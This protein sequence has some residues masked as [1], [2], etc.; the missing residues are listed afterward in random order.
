ML[1][2]STKCW[3]PQ[4]ISFLVTEQIISANISHQNIHYIILLL[5]YSILKYFS[6]S[7]RSLFVIAFE[8]C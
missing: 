4:F 3:S 5:H 6:L 8:F 2:K 1:K 7:L